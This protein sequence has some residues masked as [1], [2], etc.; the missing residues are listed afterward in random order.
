MASVKKT[1]FDITMTRGDTYNIVF[2]VSK[3]TTSDLTCA[4]MTCKEKE[5]PE[6]TAKFCKKLSDGGI[7]K[8]SSGK[9]K[10]SLVRADTIDLDVE[11]QY[12]YDVEVKYGNEIKT[13]ICGCFKLLQD[14]TTP[15][16]EGSDG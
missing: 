4:Y 10:I 14:Y 16:D 11:G 12:M 15:N 3:L 1:K 8:I 13:I 7:A 5:A 2:D 6:G 9:Y